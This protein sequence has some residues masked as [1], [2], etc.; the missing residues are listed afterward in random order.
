[1]RSLQSKRYPT[2]RA[3]HSRW[4]WP[5]EEV[6]SALSAW[7]YEIK[8]DPEQALRRAQLFSQQ[9]TQ[10]AQERAALRARA[11]AEFDG[12]SVEDDRIV[13]TYRKAYISEEMMLAQ[14]DQVKARRDELQA[15][16][17]QP[18]ETVR[19]LSPDDDFFTPVILWLAGQEKEQL[20][21]LI[22][23]AWLESDGGLTVEGLLP[24][25]SDTVQEGASPSSGLVETSSLPSCSRRSSP[26][27]Y[28]YSVT[29]AAPV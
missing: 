16:L 25:L 28:A 18:D 8:Q 3:T 29:L 1:M 17:D 9:T 12:L 26:Y 21:R 10:H 2:S 5:V 14:L 19:R 6:E 4:R 20:T 15:T 24:S 23:V 22:S 11:R 27:S 13:T 7:V